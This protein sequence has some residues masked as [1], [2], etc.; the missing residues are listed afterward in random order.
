MKTSLTA[1]VAGV[2][3]SVGLGLGGMTDPSKV[4]G[5]LDVTGDWNPSLMFVMGGALGT[6]ALLRRFI[7]RRPAPVL[8]PAFLT[9]PK[10]KPDRR[11]FLGATL[12]GIGW[13]LGGYCPGPAFT[14]IASGATATLMFV[15]AMLG[16]MLLFHL[17]ERRL[18]RSP[19]GG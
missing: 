8:A 14:S 12:F 16:G 5:F 18:S 11:L 3:F 15:A 17:W 19:A 6:H 13:G 1:L 4:Q 7:V 10:G 9:P 2:L